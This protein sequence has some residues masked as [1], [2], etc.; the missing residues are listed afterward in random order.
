MS[1][2]PDEFNQDDPDIEEFET[3]M[4]EFVELSLNDKL[5]ML[6][7]HS[8]NLDAQVNLANEKLSLILVNLGYTFDDE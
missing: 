2:S 5:M 1:I 4:Q 3:A 6:Y 8:K 7:A